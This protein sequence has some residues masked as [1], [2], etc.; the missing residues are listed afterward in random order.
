M[1]KQYLEHSKE[2][3]TSSSSLFKGGSKGVPIISLFGYRNEY[4]LREGFPFVTTKEVKLGSVIHELLWFMRGGTNV[5]YLVDNGV[6]IWNTDAFNHNL[7]GMIRED[8]FPKDLV[9][10]SSDWNK[11]LK[12]Y[13]QRIKEDEDFASRWG[14]LGPVYGAQWRN[15]KSVGENGEIVSVD[16]LD[17][18][19][20]TLRRKPTSK[21]NLITAWNPGDLPKMALEPCHILYQSNS[22]GEVLDI[23]MYQR[24]C[25]QFLGVPFN[26]ASYAALTHIVAHET[27]LEARRFSHVFGDSHFYC[28]SGER[29]SWYGDNLE[30]LQEQVRRAKDPESYLEVLDWINDAA[31]PELDSDGNELKGGHSYDHVT[32]IIKQLSR[33]PRELPKLEI[34]KR[35][36]DELTIDDFKLTGYDPAPA[37]RR[38]MAV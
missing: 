5:K 31:P 32:A 4:D 10:Y 23:Q 3:L 15:W 22:D 12:E 25:D 11:V 21:K 19:I 17:R 20:D 2:I 24:S 8:I 34:A 29:G 35:P 14:G 26:I 7:D 37:I 16:Q 38:K 27:G 9:K 33:E 28:G 18:F 30:R 36:Y 13:G 6:S 1:V